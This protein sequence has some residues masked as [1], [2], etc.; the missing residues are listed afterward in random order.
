MKTRMLVGACVCAGIFAGVSGVVEAQQERSRQPMASP[1]ATV[2]QVIG[3]DNEITIVY[4]RPGV[5][6]RDVWTEKSAN[7]AIG[8][9]V[10]REGEPRPW[11]A[12]A[13]NT[14]TITFTKDVKIEGQAVPAG[15]YGLFMIPRD[16]KWTVIINKDAKGWGS[17]R[18]NQEQDV[19][20]VDVEPVE[21][22]E[23]EWLIYGFEDLQ[24]WGATAYLHWEKVKVP[25]KIT[26]D[27]E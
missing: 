4:H 23:Q 8:Q 12:G 18:Y 19:V 26:M 11:R 24:P 25:F 27:E 17:F 15:E 10:P 21:A 6:G 7:P 5:K 20:R 9:L 16:D 1:K 14:T 13:N 2:S 22:P 3:V